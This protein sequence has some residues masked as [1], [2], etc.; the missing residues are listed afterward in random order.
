MLAVEKPGDLRQISV[1]KRRG[2][3]FGGKLPPTT[4]VKMGGCPP[5]ETDRSQLKQNKQKNAQ[6]VPH[7]GDFDVFSAL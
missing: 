2:G 4:G 6:N 3:S 5:V 7:L 1:E